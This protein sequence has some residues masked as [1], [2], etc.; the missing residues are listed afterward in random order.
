MRDLVLRP[1]RKLS[2]K[3]DKVA[4]KIFPKFEG[5]IKIKCRSSTIVFTLVNLNGNYVGNEH[6][7]NFQNSYEAQGFPDRTLRY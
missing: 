1:N 6:V 7:D 3:F 4:G 2:K 5:P